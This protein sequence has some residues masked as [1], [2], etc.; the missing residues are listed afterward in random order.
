MFVDQPSLLLALGFTAFALASTLFVT[1]LSAR[2][3]RFILLW[4]TGA[5]VLVIAFASFSIFAVTN[6]Y[7]LGWFSNMLL[8][9]GFVLLYG[10]GCLFSEGTVPQRRL[11]Y[12]SAAA[13]ALITLPFALGLSGLGAIAGNLINASLLTATG[14]AFWRRRREFPVWITGISLLYWLAALS[15]IPCAVV[16]AL[17]NPL[18]LQAPPSGW[19]EDLNSIIGLV[20]MTGIGA[21]SLALNQA[22][23]ASRNLKMARTDVLTGLLNRRALF[24]LYGTDSADPAMAVIVFDLD[25]FKTINDTHGHAVGDEVIKRFA[26]VIGQCIRPGDVAARPGGEEFAVVMTGVPLAAVEQ[27]AERVRVLFE[28][29]AIVSEKGDFRATVSAGVAH[30]DGDMEPF[31]SLLRRADQQ[32][33]R[34]KESGRNRVLSARI[35]LAAINQ[36]IRSAR[37]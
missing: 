2:G 34:A 27:A 36:P 29:E 35:K 28:S 26:E 37:S 30:A 6:V 8:S 31:E 13:A 9:S 4:S 21:L 25:H 3:D 5:G 18:V 24:D 23:I 32:L 15:F 14:L 17:K 11:A 1:W 16:I 10:A 33:Y 20:T 7:V 22:R 12:V 19:A